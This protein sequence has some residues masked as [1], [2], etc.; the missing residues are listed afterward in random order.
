[1]E[2]LDPIKASEIIGAKLSAELRKKIIIP[3]EKEDISKAASEAVDVVDKKETKKETKKE[4][5]PSMENY[6]SAMKGYKPENDSAKPEEAVENEKLSELEKEV[7]TARKSFVGK[8]IEAEKN[9]SKFWKLFRIGSLG[10]YS[11]EHKQVK[12]KYYAA[13]KAYKDEY[14]NTHGLN[15]K[16]VG[17]MVA[18]FNIKEHYNL[19]SARLDTNNENANW[20]KKAWNGYMGMIDRYRKI[21]EKDKSKLKKYSKKFAAGM[22]V[23]VA[24]TGLAAGGGAAAGAAGTIAGAALVRGFTIG[25][26]S[27]GFKTLY[28]GL[29]Q[30]S[31]ERENKRELNYISRNLKEPSLGESYLNRVNQDLDEKINSIDEVLQEQKQGKR[32]RTIAAVGTAVIISQAGRYCGRWASEKMSHWLGGM[33]APTGEIPAAK[34]AGEVAAPETVIEKNIDLPAIEKGGSIEGS[35]IKHLTDNPDLIERYNE[36]LGGSRKFD[37]GQIAHRMFEEYG[38]KRDL[39]HAGAQVQLSSDGLHIQGV[40][41][42]ENTGFLHENATEAVATE[43]EIKTVPDAVKEPEINA[44]PDNISPEANVFPENFGFERAHGSIF[45]HNTDNFLESAERELFNAERGYGGNYGPA[46]SPTPG[47]GLGSAWFE[48]VAANRNFFS[49]FRDQ[50]ISGNTED[51]TKVFQN[52]IAKGEKWNIIKNM[53]VSEATDKAGWRGS[54]VEELFKNMQKVLGTSLKPN[55]FPREETVAEWTKRV[56]KTAVE[57]ANKKY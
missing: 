6:F 12:E 45:G 25:V 48:N 19:E 35:I 51:A 37:A 46:V 23:A 52:E 53:A 2:K 34:P 17:E 18:F 36:Q 29:A 30:G 41:G 21:G 43:P 5:D 22:F 55:I 39:A 40:A 11:E 28:E 26:S 8:D 24:A 50:I 4:K 56:V 31:K 27:V 38:D 15:E 7:E 13:L 1:M 3:Q 10:E 32:F 16:S 14:L 44:V 42:D 54:K 33:E 20:P 57:Q 49:A 9:S 47:P